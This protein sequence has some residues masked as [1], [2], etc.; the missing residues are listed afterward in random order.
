MKINFSILQGVFFLIS[1]VSLLA[2]PPMIEE[3]EEQ[4]TS[5]INYGQAQIPQNDLI[6]KGASKSLKRSL[7]RSEINS[8]EDNHDHLNKNVTPTS[9][10]LDHGEKM[11]NE[12]GEEDQNLTEI[13]KKIAAVK[14]QAQ[15]LHQSFL[16]LSPMVERVEDGLASIISDSQENIALNNFTSETKGKSEALSSDEKGRGKDLKSSLEK[17]EIILIEDDHEYPNENIANELAIEYQNIAKI[18]KKA[19]KNKKQAEELLSMGIINI[20]AASNFSRSS[21]FL[22]KQANYQTQAIEARRV[23]ENELAASYRGMVFISKYAADYFEQKTQVHSFKKNNGREC[24]DKERLSLALK[25]TY[26][27]RGNKSQET[28]LV[29]PYREVI[30]I[31]QEAAK[32][33]YQEL[34]ALT[35]G[36]ERKSSSY[37]N[38]SQYLQSK[39]KILESKIKKQIEDVKQGESTLSFENEKVKNNIALERKTNLHRKRKAIEIDDSDENMG[40]VI[41]CQQ[42]LAEKRTARSGKVLSDYAIDV[43]KQGA[44]HD[45]INAFEESY[46]KVHNAFEL[47]NYPLALAFTQVAEDIQQVIE[48]KIKQIEAFKNHKCE[49]GNFWQNTARIRKS[50]AESREQ[51]ILAEESLQESEVV[52]HWKKIIEI[53]QPAAEFLKKVGE[54]YPVENQS[55]QEAWDKVATLAMTSIDQI[56]ESFWRLEQA[57]QAKNKGNLAIADLYFKSA[58]TTQTL[59]EYYQQAAKDYIS[60]NPVI[61]EIWDPTDDEWVK[62]NTLFSSSLAKQA[63]YQIKALEA[64]EAGKMQLVASYLEI[65]LT[66]EGAAD[67]FERS[68]QAYAL[69]KNHESECWHKAALSLSLRAAYQE[70]KNKTKEVG[71]SIP[72]VYAELIEM[73]QEAAKYYC[74]QAKAITAGNE[75]ERVNCSN[76]NKYIESKVQFLISKVKKQIEITEKLKETDICTIESKQDGHNANILSSKKVPTKRPVNNTKANMALS[77]CCQQWLSQEKFIRRPGEALSN[78]VIEIL[79][80][81]AD[82]DLINAFEQSYLNV[83]DAFELGNYP[84]ALAFTQVTEDIQQV[85]TSKFKEEEA[86]KNNEHRLGKYWGNIAWSMRCLAK[87]REQYILAE[88]SLQE[89]ETVNA[90]KKNAQNFQT[91][92]EYLKKLG[93][94]YATS[95]QMNKKIWDKASKSAETLFDKLSMINEKFKK[96]TAMAD[97]NLKRATTAQNKGNLEIATF[98]L[99]SVEQLRV[100]AGYHQQATE[101]YILAHQVAEE[102]WDKVDQSIEGI[103]R[104]LHTAEWGMKKINSIISEDSLKTITPYLKVAQQSLVSTE[105]YGQAIEA[106]ASGNQNMGKKMDR[107]GNLTWCRAKRLK[108]ELCPT[109]QPCPCCFGNW[110]ISLR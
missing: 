42:W 28:I 86:F 110:E 67:Y 95:T 46:L 44:D 35:T 54:A 84:L 79:K 90:L 30:E 81:G 5:S 58:E 85:I 60:E 23:G 87:Y 40:L 47:G 20:A 100:F 48:S 2:L 70:Q 32:F 14:K 59:S 39:A 34:E 41:R 109:T 7:E 91:V 24:S 31:L 93:V 72:V 15:R 27:E 80:R 4:L 65:A 52:N 104:G 45:L 38:V 37:S 92:T 89:P 21:E 74:L 10:D 6:A 50:L 53:L 68:V 55:E 11:A 107:V 18:F 94:T 102:V 78:Y 29:T 77:I 66:L 63:N 61:E 19:E 99:Q 3:A 26:Q 73:L 13:L 51:C 33:Y 64:Q 9:L 62:I 17:P 75:Q 8:I 22:V 96:A 106:Y 1:T 43:L 101:A 25:A 108:N 12:F 98:Y 49:L 105:Y 83:H 76:V 57:T 56:Y 88:E 36:N 16:T 71:Q 97:E 69:G 82:H 103:V